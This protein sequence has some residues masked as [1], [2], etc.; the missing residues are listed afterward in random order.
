MEKKR[1]IFMGTP[2]I[3]TEYLKTLINNNFNIIGVYTQPPSPKGRGMIVQNSPV[4]NEA[5][6]NSIPV[7]LPN[8]FIDQKIID[9]FVNLKADLAI[10]MAYGKLLPESILKAPKCGCINVHLSL[11]PQW[12]GAAPIEHAL[13]NGD[14]K[15]GVTIFRLVNKFDAGPILSKSPI[16]IDDKMNKEDLFNKLNVVGKDLLI[17]TILDYFNNKIILEEQDE[18]KATYAKKILSK[19][20]K[21]N[22]EENVIKV[23]NKIRAFS[24]KPGAWFM[25]KN[26]RIKILKCQTFL[27]DCNPSVIENSKFHIGCKG[28]LIEPVIMQREGKKPMGIGEFLKGFKFS[29]GQ[30][31]NVQ[32]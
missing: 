10:V 30:K 15:T 19:H 29:I 27:K 22:F 32:I 24:P 18:H 7:F 28:G 17:K 14:K 8:N 12:R 31:V 23:F 2:L 5:L 25:F 3:S 11:L 6:K 9:T 4:H 1:I 26:E 13:I 16:F 20:R 21:I